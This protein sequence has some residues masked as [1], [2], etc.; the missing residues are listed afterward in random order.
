MMPSKVNSNTTKDLTR[1]EGDDTS[2]SEFKR[3]MRIIEMKE[4]MQT[5]AN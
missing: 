1:N 5:Q 4:D 3:K 2:I